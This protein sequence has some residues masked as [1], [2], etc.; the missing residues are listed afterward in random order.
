M[1]ET[2]VNTVLS[3]DVSLEHRLPTS[4]IAVAVDVVIFSLIDGDLKVLLIRREREPFQRMYAIPG[5]FVEP[6]ESLE[7]AALRILKTETGV[8]DV[9]LEQLYTFGDIDRDPRARVVSVTYFAL[10]RPDK[11]QLPPASEATGA[12]WH[13]MVYLAR[14]AFDHNLILDYALKRLRYKLEYSAV[15]FELMPEEFTL[16]ELQEAY[17]VILNDHTLDKANFRKRLRNEPPIIEPTGEERKTKGRPAALY[18][19]REDAKREVKARRLFP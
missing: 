16:R 1:S 13:S 15:A 14:L 8:Q 6:D 7:S 10:L 17:M 18:R 11:I 12:A 4:S 5:G 3:P 9:Y 19:F 2:T